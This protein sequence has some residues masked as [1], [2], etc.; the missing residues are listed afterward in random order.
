MGMGVLVEED[1]FIPICAKIYE[2]ISKQRE[3][4]QKFKNAKKYFKTW[5]N[6]CKIL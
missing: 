1:Q 6:Y 4:L 3:L 5:G 2:K